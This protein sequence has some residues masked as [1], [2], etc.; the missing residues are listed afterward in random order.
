VPLADDAP[1]PRLAASWRRLQAADYDVAPVL[2]DGVDGEWPGDLPGRLILG[3]SRLAAVTGRAP[4]QLQDLVHTLPGRLNSAGHLGPVHHD[5]TDEQQLAG[6]GWLVSGLLAHHRLTGENASRELA[7]GMV[8]GLFLPAAR[9]L[10]GYPKRQPGDSGDGGASGT[11]VGRRGDWLLSTDTYCVFI[12]LEALVTAYA[13][14]GDREIG[15]AVEALAE[16]V[17]RDDLVV[18]RAQLHATLT[19]ARCL[20][21]YH[22]LT[23]RP[24][25]LATARRLYEQYAAHGRT[26]NAATWNWFGRSDTWTEP[27]AVTD[28]LILAL[29]LWRTTGE[30]RYLAD[31]HAIEHNGLGHAQ[32][33]H[34]GF[35]LDTITGPGLPWLANHHSD[36]AWC[37]TMR[38]AVA[39]AELRERGY[40]LVPGQAQQPES[41]SAVGAAPDTLSVGLF[42]D[43]TTRLDLPQGRLVLRQRTGYPIDGAVALD[44]VESSLPGPLRI[45]FELPPWTDP[46]RTVL[47]FSGP[48]RTEAD[49]PAR[50][51]A[52]PRAGDRYR[53]EFPVGLRTRT[54]GDDGDSYTLRHGVL[55]LGAHADSPHPAWPV[56]E[57]VE[58]V[59][60][61]AGCYRLGE[62]AL[63]P[64]GDVFSGTE[65]AA[66]GYRARVVF[67]PGRR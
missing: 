44:V 43:G 23:G 24:G 42:R 7:L 33:P 51:L 2:A 46:G 37:C 36:A 19:A 62:A 9:R 28:S 16:L 47:S 66:A 55:L 30:P 21:A 1:D 40:L 57:Q 56:L 11:V 27:C 12:A 5:A 50:L 60:A 13:T 58:P 4:R 41:A 8:E 6:H 22:E 39:L 3:L 59:D 63:T 32:K 31:A 17:D 25:P 15:E 18:A 53:V 52:H 49:G 29:G 45:R 38:G 26:A 48:G 65:Q 54:E 10:P 67:G 61:G 14:T 34:G 35:G 64:V 20:H